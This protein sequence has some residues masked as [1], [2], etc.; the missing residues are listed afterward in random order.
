MIATDKHYARLIQAWN[1]HYHIFVIVCSH[2]CKTIEVWMLI[3]IMHICKTALKVKLSSFKCAEGVFWANDATCVQLWW[4]I[5]QEWAGFFLIN[6]QNQLKISNL[7]VQRN[8]KRKTFLLKT[9][10]GV[11]RKNGV[12][13][14]QHFSI[15]VLVQKLVFFWWFFFQTFCVFG[16]LDISIILQC[17]KHQ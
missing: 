10:E 1:N 14:M 16:N 12:F 3:S 17:T 6:P 9:V 4:K 8:S 7:H 13:Y 5:Y 15:P 2:N 11:I